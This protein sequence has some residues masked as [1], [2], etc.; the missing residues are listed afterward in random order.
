MKQ[1][2][3][4]STG[5]RISVQ[6][7]THKKKRW[8]RAAVTDRRTLSNWILQACDAYVDMTAPTAA[9]SKRKRKPRR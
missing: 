3:P 4:K 6:V 1:K 9:V 8:A 2:Q 5:D 7:S